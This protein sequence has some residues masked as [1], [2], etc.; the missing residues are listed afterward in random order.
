VFTPRGGVLSV[1]PADAPAIATVVAAA[2]DAWRER[3]GRQAPALVGAPDR[4]LAELVF[5]ATR[6]PANLPERGIW[7]PVAHPALPLWLRPFGGRALVVLDAEGRY[8]AGVGIKRH[9]R[10]AWELSVATEPAARGMG[11]ARALVAQAARAVIA[12]GAIALYLH[13]PG[14]VASARVADAAGFPDRGWRQLMLA[15][16]PHDGDG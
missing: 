11:L 8:L 7:L 16:L 10:F 6:L 15:E 13:E 2:P 5:R 1:P 3:L 14:N 12:S 9:S 4:S